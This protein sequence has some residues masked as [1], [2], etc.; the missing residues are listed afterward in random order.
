MKPRRLFLKHFV[1]AF[2]LLT[3]STEAKTK[4]KSTR[5][6]LTTLKV[7]GLQYGECVDYIF[8]SHQQLEL[9]REPSNRYD[10]YAV[11]LHCKRKKVGYIPRTNSRIIASLM[12]TGELIKVQVRYFYPNKEPWE[13]LWVSLYKVG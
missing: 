6:K 9:V 3:S 2:A 5:I 12:D 4:I 13:R 8:A 11:A 1:S 10:R 7:A